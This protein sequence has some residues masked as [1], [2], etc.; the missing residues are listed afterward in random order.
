MRENLWKIKGLNTDTVAELT[1]E[2]VR[3]QCV[4]EHA[5]GSVLS[6]TTSC[7]SRA[8]QILTVATLSKAYQIDALNQHIQCCENL[9]PD[10][11]DVPY[12]SGTGLIVALVLPHLLKTVLPSRLEMS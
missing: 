11:D 9:P 5:G 7:V 12:V 2:L 10:N 4:N 6:K 8:T 3:Q 1:T